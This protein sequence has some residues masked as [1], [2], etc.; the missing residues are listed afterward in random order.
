MQLVGDVTDGKRARSETW[1][2]PKRREKKK[3][4]LGG[5]MGGKQDVKSGP[6]NTL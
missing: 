3:T 5:Q 1:W 6:G 2:A 4:G